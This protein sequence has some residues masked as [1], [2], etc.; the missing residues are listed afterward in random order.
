MSEGPEVRWTADKLRTALLG[1]EIVGVRFRPRPEVAAQLVG[2]TVTTSEAVGKHLIVGF[3]SGWWLRNHMLMYGK[4][5]TYPRAEFDAGRSRAPRRSMA[6]RKPGRPDRSDTADV[7]TDARVRLVLET[8]EMAAVQFNGPVIEFGESDPRLGPEIQR[9][10]P[11]ALA[12]DFDRNEALRR[13][14]DRAQVTLADVVLDQSVVAGVGNK[15]KAELL[16]LL[17][18]DPFAQVADLE[19]AEREQLVDAIPTLLR[20]AYQNGG[21]TRRAPGGR[22]RDAS[23]WVYGRAGRP[24]HRCGTVVRS[25][26]RRS[27]RRT[28]FCPTCQPS[29]D[30]GG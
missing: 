7:R 4:W 12:A 28:Y 21:R 13:L 8:P 1:R 29:R 22:G 14:A 23:L 9:L 19:A 18:A 27:A 20:D 15:Y 2:S 16:F 10:G 11:D 25:D 30:P 6:Y 5:R 24:C 26:A 3:S 17:G